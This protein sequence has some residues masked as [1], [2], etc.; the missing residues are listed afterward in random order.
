MADKCPKCG[1]RGWI[2]DGPGGR[3]ATCNQCHGKLGPRD[4]LAQSQ[5]RVK[6]LE[7]I[8]DKFHAIHA[9]VSHC[10]KNDGKDG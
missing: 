7:A 5:A 8:I 3:T 4:Q 9:D 10:R 2:H 6:E 1:G